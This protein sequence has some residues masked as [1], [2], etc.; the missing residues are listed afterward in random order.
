ML[1]ILI[2]SYNKYSLLASCGKSIKIHL[3]WDR[4]VILA[5][6]HSYN[7]LQQ[8]LIR[9][10]RQIVITGSNLNLVKYI[11][12]EYKRVCGSL[13][14]CLIWLKI[15]SSAQSWQCE[16]LTSQSLSHFTVKVW[17]EWGQNLLIY[18]SLN[19]QSSVGGAF[20]D[21]SLNPYSYSTW[22]MKVLKD[23]LRP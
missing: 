13:T 1:S 18:C 9:K 8:Q 3:M 22:S 4:V 12:Q 15:P 19:T 10:G 5:I 23:D 6:F 20:G 14:V 7:S 11:W 16:L 17:R 2:I 21:F